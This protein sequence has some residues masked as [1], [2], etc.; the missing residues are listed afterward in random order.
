MFGSGIGELR[1]SI[2]H[3]RSLEAQM[4]EIWRLRGNAGNSWFDSRVTVSSLDD[5]QLVLEASVGNTA[6][7]DIAVDDISFSTGPCPSWYYLYNA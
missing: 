6:M 4:Q 5:Y 1:I 2:R 3:A 7:G